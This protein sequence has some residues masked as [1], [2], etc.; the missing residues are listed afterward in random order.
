MNP[1]RACRAALL[2]CLAL[3][4]VL[5]DEGMW[6][7]QQ[8]PQLAPQLRALGFAGDP[9]EFADL[10]G[11]PM[12]AIVSLGGCSASFVSPGGLIVTNH[13]CVQGA[14][15]YNATPEHNLLETGFLAKTMA[16]ELWAGPG[17]RVYVTTRV[18]D[19]TA[20]LDKRLTPKMG[21]RERFDAI[22][23]WQK[24]RT[25]ACEKDGSRCRVSSFFAG[26]KWFEIAQMEIQDVRLVYAPHEGIGNFGGETD[27]WQWPRH[28][29]DFSYY[30]AY[31]SKDGKAVP[32]SK[33]N[34]PYRPKHWLKVS[35]KGAS[36]GDLVFVAGYPGRTERHETYAQVKER[37]EWS[38]PRSIRRAKEQIAILE[39]L[40]KDSKDTAI[41]VAQ[42]KRGLNN[43]LT[44]NR[45]VLEGLTRG[46]ILDRKEA[47]EKDLLA[48]IAAD[49]ARRK[50]Y[51]DLFPALD[52]LQAE[53]EKNRERDAAVDALGGGGFGGASALLSSAMTLYRLSLERPK[54]DADRE[55]EYQERNWSR[56]REGQ[57]RM[58]KTYDP[59]ADR[60]LLRY[61][62]LE[63]ARLPADRRIAPFDQAAGLKAGQPEAEAAQAI[64]AL[65]DRL[66]A[67]TKLADKDVRLS[68]LD[69]STAEIA[70]TKDSF[71][72]FA[73]TMYPA[74]KE[75]QDRD[76]AESGAEY[77]LMPRTM[78]ALLEKN[79]GLVAPDAN[80]TLRVTFGRV[81]G[82]SPRDGV[83][84]QPQ[85]TTA[86]VVEKHTGKGEFKAPQAELDAIRAL[87]AGKATPYLDPALKDVP[88]DYLS[89]VDTTGGNSGS[90]ALNAKGELCGLLFDGTYDTVASDILY[91][92]VRTRSIQV[93]SRYMLWIMSEVDGAQ[94]LLKEMGF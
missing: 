40:S 58:Q 10:T 88:V 71:V 20:D 2:L 42:R 63:A 27:N 8:V 31:V 78:K 25:A 47:R 73:M 76:K 28:T 91:D 69:R 41:R 16:D 87:R 66:Y 68:L 52:A 3:T 65:L 15:Q 19:V 18:T 83:F 7:P 80:G 12:G 70:A 53:H 94:N 92:T 64:D 35:P 48:W 6:M 90:A 21:D 50:E 60:A 30:R 11:Q 9:Q 49:P 56:I 37:T 14:L 29:G 34:V 36:P 46:G 1:R 22:E 79:G 77:R 81:M 54:P 62:M 26:L 24:E 17:S 86:G 43:G 51:G 13:H 39:E 32:F 61:V 74:V 33:D 55:P 75:K 84:Y 5:A 57:E 4:P 59:R 85:T 82:V 44:K 93:D 89:T 23:A 38:L 45:G 67:G 72:E